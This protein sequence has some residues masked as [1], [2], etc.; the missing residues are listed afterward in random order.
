MHLVLG[1]ATGKVPTEKKHV[2]QRG[3]GLGCVGMDRVGDLSQG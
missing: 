3:R 1:G 2:V